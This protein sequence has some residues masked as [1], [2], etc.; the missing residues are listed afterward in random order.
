V[1]FLEL[2]GNALGAVKEFFGFA[3]Q[4]DSERN[5]PDMKQ[6]KEAKGEAAAVDQTRVALAKKDLDELRR[7]AAE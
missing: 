2:I 4:R 6:A 3:K 7:E 5:T 1:G